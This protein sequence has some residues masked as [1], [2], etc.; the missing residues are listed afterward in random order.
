MVSKV[1][2]RQSFFIGPTPCASVGICSEAG[3]IK[4]DL[5]VFTAS[6]REF[7]IVSIQTNTLGGGDNIKWFSINT[8]PECH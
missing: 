8:D 7:G 3:I 6:R 4:L 2:N 5:K 1:V